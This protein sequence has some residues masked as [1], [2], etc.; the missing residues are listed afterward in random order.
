MLIKST[1]NEIQKLSG[2][3]TN[4]TRVTKNYLKNSQI[5]NQ[6]ALLIKKAR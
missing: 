5:L 6:S 2:R 4:R 3:N 1:T